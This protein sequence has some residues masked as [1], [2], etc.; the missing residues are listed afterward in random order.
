M[1]QLV[2]RVKAYKTAILAFITAASVWTMLGSFAL[3]GDE[4]TTRLANGVQEQSVALETPGGFKAFLVGADDYA[5]KNA[6]DL[7][8]VRNDV[9]ALAKR[10]IK[11]GF[12]EKN[13]FVL[14]TGDDVDFSYF[15]TKDNI[16]KRYDEFL[17]GLKKND[18]AV[19][20]MS[21]HGFSPDNSNESF[22]APID[23]KSEDPFNSSVSVDKMLAELGA[24]DAKFRWMIVDA[25]RNDPTEQKAIFQTKG[26]GDIANA[27]ETTAILQSCQS[28]ERSYGGCYGDNG[29][30]A[31]TLSLL[32]A[33]DENDSPADANDDRLLTFAEMLKYVSDRTGELAWQY[34]RERQNPIAQNKTPDFI[35]LKL[36]RSSILPDDNERP[37]VI[38]NGLEDVDGG[39][40]NGDSIWKK[41]AWL[42]ATLI[43]I[44]G[45]AARGARSTPR[46]VNAKI[47]YCAE[48]DRRE[49]EAR[50]EVAEAFEKCRK[51]AG[52]K[53]TDEALE[54]R[55]QAAE[56]GDPEAMR[57]LGDCY[58]DGIGVDVNV[59]KA[60]EWYRKAAD[61][62]DAEAMNKMGV[63][64]SMQARGYVEGTDSERSAVEAFEWFCKA[65]DA[66]W[67]EALN[68][69]G[70]CYLN[71][72]GVETNVAQ[73]FERYR[74]AADVGNARAMN[75]LGVCYLNGEGVD[76][77]FATAF[78]WFSKAA[79]AGCAEALNNLGDCYRRG[80]YAPRDIDAAIKLYLAAAESDDLIAKERA[81]KTLMELE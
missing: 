50:Q 68:N 17:K 35:I 6:P 76:V 21:G 59:A 62:G 15:P 40:T 37:I 48:P 44:A 81:L 67:I 41:L 54:R 74:Q 66:G 8:F 51:T 45:L 10:L 1:G 13:I 60:V 5:D 79:D 26:M 55:R 31:F 2:K 70:D 32:E 61:A 30:S 71:G 75:K 18:F 46:P 34:H 14:K 23:I 36:R 65:V 43:G 33:L 58:L 7:P 4:P 25:C 19:V 42:A 49:K 73:A 57:W 20:Y 78:E 11:I 52:E 28:G 16:V 72:E 22:F 69:L 3:F 38:I 12:E 27:P 53:T 56:G 80:V 63:Y 64:C 9:E 24:S 29:V 39:K 47:D 77:N